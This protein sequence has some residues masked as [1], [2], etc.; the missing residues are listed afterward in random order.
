MPNFTLTECDTS[1]SVKSPA[2]RRHVMRQ[3]TETSWPVAGSTRASRFD[4]KRSDELNVVRS[5]KPCALGVNLTY[6]PSPLRATCWPKLVKN[7]VNHRR[8]KLQTQQFVPNGLICAWIFNESSTQRI[9]WTDVD[10]SYL[11]WPLFYLCIMLTSIAVCVI[12]ESLPHFFFCCGVRP[13]WPGG[14]LFSPED[15][16]THNC[17]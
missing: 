4:Y 9:P 13:V 2:L 6:I 1:R 14:G 16:V 5:L 15:M 7:N 12:F 3:R 8:A 10:Y 11:E 17:K